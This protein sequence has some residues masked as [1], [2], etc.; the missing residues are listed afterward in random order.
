MSGWMGVWV[1]GSVGG[2]ECEWVDE[3]WWV[4]GSMGG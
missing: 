2:W 1:G 4:D 3:C